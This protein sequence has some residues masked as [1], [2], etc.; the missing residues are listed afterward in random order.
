MKL[1]AIIDGKPAQI[2]IL[3]PA[4]ACRF[5]LDGEERQADVET[6][7]AGVYSI[8]MDGRQ[9]EAR[10]EEHAGSLVVLA[11]DFR[12]EIEVRDPRRLARRA[13]VGTREGVETI[14][15]PMPGKVVR[16]LAA[17]GDAVEAGR[18]LVVVEAMKMQNELKASRAGRVLEVRAKEGA[19]VAAG[20]ALVTI[21]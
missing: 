8:V 3:A 1:E 13:G 6:P 9:Y 14:A 21:E 19:T 17:P 12:F 16:V 18:G 10:I 4:P 7:E 15:A 5:R 2:E 11:G 20:E